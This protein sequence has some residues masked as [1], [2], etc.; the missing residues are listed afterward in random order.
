MTPS[1]PGSFVSFSRNDYRCS[2]L[3]DPFQFTRPR[4]SPPL[5][6]GTGVAG[7]SQSSQHHHVAPTANMDIN[8]SND[9]NVSNDN[10]DNYEN[11][12]NTTGEV[13]DVIVVGEAGGGPLRPLANATTAAGG[14]YGKAPL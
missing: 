12:D 11:H 7:P 3:T 4:H 5:A 10:N 9:S 1:D 6:A 14:Q 8:N 13:R 2:D